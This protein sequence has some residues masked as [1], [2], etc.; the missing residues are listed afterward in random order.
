VKA[1]FKLKYKG[2]LNI[3]ESPKEFGLSFWEGG[4][5]LKMDNQT[6]KVN[7]MGALGKGK[8]VEVGR[9]YTYFRGRGSY[10]VE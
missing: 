3:L 6:E 2:L 5:Y 9:K 8:R 1:T 10:E 7:T 4:L